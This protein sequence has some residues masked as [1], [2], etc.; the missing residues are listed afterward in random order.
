MRLRE[1]FRLSHREFIILKARSIAT[2][3]TIGVLFGVLLAGIVILQGMENV[4]LKYAGEKT[5]YVINLSFGD[6]PSNLDHAASFNNVADAS[7]FYDSV[8]RQRNY[9]SEKTTR[10]VAT[11]KTYEQYKS[12]LRPLV[13]ILII[14]A[15][16][17]LSFTFGH[18][19]SQDAN[20]T[21]LYYSLGASRLQVF[22]VYFCYILEICFWAMVFA[23]VLAII[24]SGIVT[25]IGW[26]NFIRLFSETH[27][28]STAFPPILI[29]VNW[30]CAT[31]L[32]AMY[33]SAP[34]AFL[35][36]LDQLSRK[37]LALKLKKS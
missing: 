7:I 26:D 33:A 36:C 3:I 2:V 5:N 35:L 13:L 18:V 6:E 34:L 14:V 22:A 25:C 4:E 9:I 24:G 32:I 15:I 28:N 23:I 17:I 1:I 21:A 12:Q 30:E 20:T 16:L 8:T 31:I 11:Y 19:I 29:G 10:Q 27:Q 37:R